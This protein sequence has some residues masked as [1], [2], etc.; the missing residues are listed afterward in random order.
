MFTNAKRLY[1]GET[2]VYDAGTADPPTTILDKF[3]RTTLGPD[4]AIINTLHT[5]DAANAT[6][7]D[8]LLTVTGYAPAA[9]RDY[10][11]PN[12]TLEA[13]IMSGGTPHMVVRYL[14]NDNWIS[15]MPDN[16]GAGRIRTRIAGVSYDRT[17]PIVNVISGDFVAIELDGVYL[18]FFHNF[19]LRLT[20]VEDR[21][22]TGT[23]HGLG[24]ASATANNGWKRLSWTPRTTP[25]TQRFY[26]PTAAL[27][28]VDAATTIAQL[29]SSVAGVAT[30]L[31]G[32]FEIH[33]TPAGFALGTVT[34]AH[35]NLKVA[36]KAT[37]RA[38]ARYPREFLTGDPWVLHLGAD[39]R[40]SGAVV[41][42]VATGGDAWVNI[43]PTEV[44]LTSVTPDLPTSFEHTVHHELA[45]I[46]STFRSDAHGVL[47]TDFVASNPPGF[48]YGGTLVGGPRPMGFTRGYGT[49][50]LEEDQADVMAWLMTPGL[51]PQFDEWVATDTSLGG[52]KRAMSMYASHLDW[53]AGIFG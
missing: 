37:I 29:R 30:F 38:L 13:L 33:E 2:L 7:S 50:S 25:A 9:I 44:Q 46:L 53:G 16:G 34:F 24:G 43:D 27:A 8:S 52:K 41:S 35:P 48:T 23:K 31:G 12:G 36:V 4:Y 10:G 42:G 15:W 45:H 47:Q 49:T 40:A 51:Q 3:D 18:R 19:A 26:D 20:V 39:V 5:G 32:T 1:V 11:A 21:L 6:V 17:L 28:M 22:A 14:D